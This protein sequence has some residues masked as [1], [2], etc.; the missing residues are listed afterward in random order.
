MQGRHDGRLSA[1]DLSTV[2]WALGTFGYAPP[3]MPFL[4]A[5]AEARLDQFNEQDLANLMY[6]L[7]ACSAPDL[8]PPSLLAAA[9]QRAVSMASTLSPQVQALRLPSFRRACP[10]AS[11]PCPASDVCIR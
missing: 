11:G 4:V 6:G 5:L 8:A 1:R 9:E 10:L 2:V 3:R 7:A